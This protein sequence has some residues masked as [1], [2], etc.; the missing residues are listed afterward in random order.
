MMMGGAML[1]WLL[2]L[3]ML[4]KTIISRFIAIIA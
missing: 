1:M 4:K 2:F 3:T